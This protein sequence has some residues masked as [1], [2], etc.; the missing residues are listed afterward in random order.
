[1]AQRREPTLRSQWLGQ[2]LRDLREERGIKL[3]DLADY[4]ERDA[5]TVGRYESGETALRRVDLLAMLDYYGVSDPEIRNR[6]TDLREE[7]W[8]KGW[9]DGYK[10]VMTE[11]EF[12][13]LTWLESRARRMS[14]Y[15][16][17][18]V[19]GLLQTRAYAEA[20]IRHDYETPPE[21]V[22]RMVRLRMDRQTQWAQDGDKQ[23]SIVVDQSVLHRVIGSRDVLREQIEHLVTVSRQESVHLRV[24][25]LTAGVHRGLNGS[26]T[27]FE[28][29]DPYP[30]VAYLETLAGRVFAEFGRVER[31]TAAY[32][33]L[34]QASMPA[35]ESAELIA[36]IA[37]DLSRQ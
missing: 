28:P 31:F 11:R 5:T 35:E 13:D 29:D 14:I 17:M 23:L 2:Q 20:L 36:S 37:K 8:Q 25:P 30:D 1:M 3:A 15:A 26:F 9:W 12:V 7:A 34:E 19:T 22:D 21:H 24:L 16:A 4:L 33:Q 10:D 27:V 6:L 18:I 32:D